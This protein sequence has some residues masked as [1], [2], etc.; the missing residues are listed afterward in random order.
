M[1]VT[2][3]SAATQFY[4]DVLGLDIGMDLGWIGTCVAPDSPSVQLSVITVDASAPLTPA[5]S[6]GVDDVDSA[7][8]QAV[9][10]GAEIVY[11][12]T[13]EPWGV[14]RFFLRDAD[15]NVVNVVAHRSS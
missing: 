2:D 11:P 7:F 8:A 15:G 5:V 14:R 12:L 13:D 3:V 10:T 1:P 4:A 9:T 6:I